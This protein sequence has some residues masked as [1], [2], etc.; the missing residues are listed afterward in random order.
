MEPVMRR[1]YTTLVIV[2]CLIPVFL[3]LGK[4]WTKP[5]TKLMNQRD[6]LAENFDRD[7]PAEFD[8][9]LPHT[10]F[11]AAI[12]NGTLFENSS[13]GTIT[14]S[15]IEFGELVLPTGKI[16]GC[17]PAMLD[18]LEIVPFMRQV[19][20]GRYPVVGSLAQI[21]SG[22]STDDRVACA[23]VQFTDQTPVFWRMAH[24]ANEEFSTN[25]ELS[26]SSRGNTFQLRIDRSTACFVDVQTAERVHGKRELT[27]S[28]METM[29]ENRLSAIATIDTSGENLILFSAGFS[30]ERYLHYWGFSADKTICCLAVDFQ[31]LGDS[32]ERKKSINLHELLE[33]KLDVAVVKESGVKLRADFN[34]KL[35]QTRH[36]RLMLPK[37]LQKNISDGAKATFAEI[38]RKISTPPAGQFCCIYVRGDATDGVTVKVTNAGTTCEPSFSSSSD[39]ET[40]YCFRFDEPLESTATVDLEYYLDWKSFAVRKSGDK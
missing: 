30:N 18:Y 3:R 32:T 22:D 26:K 38:D 9:I 1:S 5:W 27:G 24:T 15:R 8:S 31:V 6:E 36:A 34:W 20:P 12:A 17:H 19:P 37:S 23:V 7:A 2:V 13:G 35:M 28:M 10:N 33:G 25:E 21:P 11:A 4:L 39:G 40:T 14:V 29:S 16:V